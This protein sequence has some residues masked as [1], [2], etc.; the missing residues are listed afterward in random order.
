MVE[1]WGFIWV[2]FALKIP[3]VMLL[4]TVWWAVHAKPEPADTE[5][6]DG[7]IGRRG[8]R[9]PVPRDPRRRGPHGGAIAPPPART[10]TRVTGRSTPPVR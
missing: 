7:G 3:L 4:W 2:M 6:E 5:Q 10:R 9:R 8:H 1:A